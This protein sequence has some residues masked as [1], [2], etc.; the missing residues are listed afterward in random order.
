MTN[1]KSTKRA[2][3]GSVMAM[4]LCLAMLVGAT[5]AWF[6]DTASTGV[7]KI[8][9]GNLDVALEMKDGDNWVSAEGKTLTFKT[10][11]NRA[12]D[13]ILWEPGCRYELPALRV[14]NKGNL[15]LKYKIQITGIQGDAKLN[16]VID[17]TI[18]DAPINLT[19]G[20][21]AAN[22]KGDSFTIKGV[23]KTTAGNEY[24]GLSIDGIGITVYASQDTVESDSF[25][26]QYDANATYYP[27]IDF[28]GLKDALGK[29]GNI[30][31]AGDFTGDKTKTGVSDR[32][33][34]KTPTTLNFEGVYTVP[35][36]LE[37]SL[38]WAAL[39][40]TDETTINAI[41]G[42][43][44][45]CEDKTDSSAAYIG[46]PYVADINAPGKTVTV[47]GGTYYGGG[48]T[49]QVTKGTLI[50]NGG[51]FQVTPDVDTHDCR[52]TLNCIDGN[53][54]N[55]SA[56]IFVKGGT[57]VNFDPSNNTA[58]GAGTNFV[59]DGYSVISETKDN[60]DVWY[61]VVK[62]TGVVPSTQDEM[63]TGITDS[64]NKDVTVVMP[65]NSSFTLDN[66]IAHEGAKSRN[67]TFS[68][69]GSQTVDV[70]TNAVSAEGGQLNYQRGSS[71]TFENLTIQAG[72][73]SFDGIVCDEL[74]YKNCTI[75]GKLTLYG[76]ATF[77]NCTFENDMANQYSIWT[78]GGTDV[79]FEGCTFNTNGKAILLY[80]Q[81][82]ESKPTNLVVNNCTFNDRNNGTAGKAAIEIGNDY[83]ATYTLTVKNATVNG[84]ADGK[85]TGSKLWANKNSM[86]V[87]HL[88]VTIDGSKVQ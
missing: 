58:E 40:I 25:N 21:L 3:L 62:G 47:N 52:Y 11:D 14:V 27:V 22:A 53:Y 57:F 6:T 70:I 74:T 59:A 23:M 20:H 45:I 75:K 54:K 88:T 19:E 65:A 76:K 29:G 46:G 85:N 78:W 17:W 50:V 33:T 8:Q 39:Y 84:F 87:A 34:I 5:F 38:N 69:N 12:A 18:N 4:V 37:A 83:N 60:G 35:G 77:I 66:G 24:Q 56:K 1:R 15:A 2:L 48:T 44:I 81:A 30:T 67:I 55:G 79:T 82:T 71:F 10:K 86:D 28:V 31:I 80:G 72:E 68:G 26:N 73:G 49:F 7:N 32:L 16:D 42:A 9:A 36:S 13:Q 51:F 63:N 41:D 43:G 61:T 64:S